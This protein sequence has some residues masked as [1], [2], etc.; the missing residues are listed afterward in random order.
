MARLWHLFI[1]HSPAS[2]AVLAVVILVLAFGINFLV[3]NAAK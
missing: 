2:Y 1:Q 3:K